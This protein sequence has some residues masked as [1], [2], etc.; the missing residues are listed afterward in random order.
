MEQARITTNQPPSQGPH[1]VRGKQPS[2]ARDPVGQAPE[3]GGGGF[4]SLLAALDSSGLQ[5][6]TAPQDG[7]LVL[8]ANE[9]VVT[10]GTAQDAPLA[11]PWMTTPADHALPTLAVD[12]HAAS[13]FLAMQTAGSLATPSQAPAASVGGWSGAGALGSLEALPRNGLVAQTA[14]LDSAAPLRKGALENDSMDASLA[15]APGGAR[16]LPTRV[17]GG[18]VSAG[19]LQTMVGAQGVQALKSQVGM[20]DPSA[21]QAAQAAVGQNPVV[22]HHG[23]AVLAREGARI[24]GQDQAPL[25]G[26][27]AP[28]VQG[29]SEGGGRTAPRSGDQGGSAATGFGAYGGNAE[30][31]GSASVDAG[32]A[33][34]DPGMSGVEDAVAEQVAFWVHQNIQ[35][36]EMTI[37]HDGQAVEVTVS[38]TGN[39]A[40]VTFGSDQA[41]TRSLLD[42]RVAELRELL[43]Q[44][45]LALSGM[46]VGESA[47]QR[48]G[49]S[50]S[51]R[52]NQQGMPRQAAVVEMPASSQERPR[53]GAGHQTDRSIDIFV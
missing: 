6:G 50:E 45:G 1:A 46:T 14:V 39:E 2:Q 34:F 53:A 11:W 21:M 48:Q 40:H 37:Q 47:Q 27:L 8:D 23:A 41:E 12:P 16:R 10:D 5:G 44:E 36:A 22:E 19:G 13:S 3:G 49:S 4:L 28:L 9:P 51:G 35:N 31:R 24:V 38:L 25:L 42:G 33:A 43:R 26:P 52:S 7:G 15:A 30:T 32:A 17:N 18:L 29:L 20:K